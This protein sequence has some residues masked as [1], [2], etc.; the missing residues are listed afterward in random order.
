MPRSQ[1][2]TTRLP[3]LVGGKEACEILGVDRKQVARWCK[4]GSGTNGSR[5]T[6]MPPWTQVAATK[7]WTRADVERFR[8]ELRA[9]AAT[10]AVR[11]RGGALPARG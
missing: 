2:S 3:G 6:K 7:I 8:E 1:W 4:D 9:E 5:R 11:E 10:K